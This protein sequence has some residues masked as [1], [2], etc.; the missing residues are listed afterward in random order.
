LGARTNAYRI[1]SFEVLAASA[2]G[3]TDRSERTFARGPASSRVLPSGAG[4]WLQVA[5]QRTPSEVEAPQTRDIA[6]VDWR[7]RSG[8][9]RERSAYTVVIYYLRWQIH[10]TEIYSQLSRRLTGQQLQHW[11]NDVIGDVSP[12]I[13]GR[14]PA[15]EHFGTPELLPE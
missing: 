8:R 9:R 7:W 11:R 12:G 1:V 10:G 4:D 15:R 5:A 2:G 6:M 3:M 14:L 13:F